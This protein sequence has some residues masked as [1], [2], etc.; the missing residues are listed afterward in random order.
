MNFAK[1]CLYIYLVACIILDELKDILNVVWKNFPQGRN[2]RKV[3]GVGVGGGR[4]LACVICFSVYLL[5]RKFCHSFIRIH[6]CTNLFLFSSRNK[7]SPSFWMD[8]FL[9]FSVC[10][11]NFF[12]LFCLCMNSLPTTTPTPP[13]TFLMACPLA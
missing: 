9:Y 8:C 5:C 3:M 7:K 11:I 10:T 13:I 4:F 6:L 2:I 1:M 12:L